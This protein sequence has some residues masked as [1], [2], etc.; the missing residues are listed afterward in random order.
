MTRIDG[1]VGGI[2]AEFRK[3]ASVDGAKLIAQNVGGQVITK[4]GIAVATVGSLAASHQIDPERKHPWLLTL[5]LAA[6]GGAV[7]GALAGAAF[8]K[9]YDGGGNRIGAIFNGARGAMFGTP[10][11]TAAFLVTANQFIG[12]A[13]FLAPLGVDKFG[14][15]CT[16][17]TRE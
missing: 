9:V 7:S 3:W 4:G 1:I 12:R 10:I 5:P 11:V 15:P 2:K 6:G 17:G 8:P 13:G 16:S 14:I